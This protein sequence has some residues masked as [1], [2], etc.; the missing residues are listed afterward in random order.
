[1]TPEKFNIV[2]LFFESA[3]K[4]PTKTAIIYKEKKISFS[5]FEK[6]VKDTSS[7]LISKGI[8]KGDRV[9]I[10][11]PMSIDLYRIVLA[12]FNIGATAVFLDEWVSKKRMEE[13]CK[14]AQCKAFVGIFKAKLFSF[15]S[16]E[17]RK[18]PIKLGVSYQRSESIDSS[19]ITTTLSDTALITF[20][21]GS[22]G[23]PKAA[24]R[25]HGFL[26]EQFNA[27]LEKI[28]PHPDD[29][30]MPVLPIVLLINLGSGC[31]SVI[32][33]FKA[34]KPNEMNTG[35]IF[36][37]IQEYKVT[38]L[39]SSPFFIKQLAKHAITTQSSLPLL[40]K[41]FTGGA[42]VFPSEAELYTN[43]FPETK[44]EIVYGSTEAEP[45]SSIAAKELV[46]EKNDILKKG[47]KVGIPYRKAQVKIIEIKTEAIT[48]TN[49]QE[50]QKLELSLGKIGE[51]IVS[52][53]HVLQEYFNNE[54]ALKLNKIF[55]GTQC[56]HRTG[57]SGY[58]DADGTIY[59]TGRCSTLI[60][61][62]DKL[63]APFIYENYFQSI[64]GI[65]MGTFLNIDN[66]LTAIIEIRSDAK[67]EF[68]V[69][70]LKTMDVIPDEIKFISKIPRDPRHNSKIDYEK[71][72]KM[73]LL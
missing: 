48:C 26:R 54:Q 43:A 63:I 6:Q 1:M 30:D 27:L 7:Y 9:L 34:S 18:I 35:K 41:I 53:P 11:V 46:K 64:D 73:P 57:D 28:D 22:T 16:A 71:L 62:G 67:K 39:V 20:T 70:L 14:V 38:R 31:T 36:G 21:T 69:N 68:I 23:T 25:T 29:I 66:K 13:C 49:E 15:F 42:P 32:A 50:L 12:L 3:A 52:G 5:E 59:L 61:K 24:K 72:K 65:E 47:L 60:H 10:F 55:I 19:T 2:N 51:I 33:D 8:G 58:I 45:I 4:Y 44:T 37:Q 40:K 56:W 17:L